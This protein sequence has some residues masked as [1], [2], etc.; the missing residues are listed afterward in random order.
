MP[1]T[2]QDFIRQWGAP[3]ELFLDSAVFETSKAIKD[4][5]R[6]YCIKDMQSE[7]NHQHQNYAEKKIQD[8]KSTANVIMDRTGEPN[9]TWYLALKYVAKL[10]NHFAS[11]KLHNKTPIEVTLGVTPNISNLIQF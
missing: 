6:H 2:L 8:V 3:S 1:E 7:P 11:Q 9:Y 4:I 10:L 5:L